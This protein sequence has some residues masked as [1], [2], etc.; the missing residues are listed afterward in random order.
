MCEIIIHEAQNTSFQG[1]AITKK[2]T[3]SKLQIII[4]III[5]IM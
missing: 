1:G 3:K 5:I 4:I 2:K